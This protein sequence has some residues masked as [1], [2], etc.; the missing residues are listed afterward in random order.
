MLLEPASYVESIAPNF[1]FEKVTEE[2]GL[3]SSTTSGSPESVAHVPRWSAG[4]VES[5]G[6]VESSQSI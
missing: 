4:F 1:M 6:Y 3:S 2:S 5:T